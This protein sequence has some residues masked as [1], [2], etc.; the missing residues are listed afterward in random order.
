MNDDES[1]FDEDNFS[2]KETLSIY[3]NRWKWY[4]I[5]TFLTFLGGYF[6]AKYAIP[7]YKASS[8]MLFRSNNPNTGGRA[9]EIDM[10][11]DL[12]I[13]DQGS[14][15]DDEIEIL[16]SRRI[17]QKVVRKLQLQNNYRS[18]GVITGMTKRTIYDN[19]PIKFIPDTLFRD[20]EVIGTTYLIEIL[21]EDEFSLL[22]NNGSQRSKTV[23]EFGEKIT[24]SSN[25]FSIHKT[26]FFTDR[27]VNSKFEVDYLNIENAVNYYKNN[28]SFEKGE[29][30]SNVVSIIFQDKS[31]ERAEAFLNELMNQYNNDATQDNR[32]VAAN[33][34]DFINE[35]MQHISMELGDVEEGVE[36][37]KSERKLV[38]IAA[39][40]SI[41][42]E[43]ESKINIEILEISTQLKLSEFVLDY[44]LEDTLKLDLIP[45][46]LGLT[47]QSIG[48]MIDSHN[49]LVLERQKTLQ[50][51][52][53]KN[54]VVRNLEGQISELKKSLIKSLKKSVE[55]NNIQLQSLRERESQIMNKISK[56][57]EYERIYRGIMRQQQI[58][59]S[60]Y[61]YLLQKREEA[62]ISYAV[63]VNNA[64]I[65]DDAYGTQIPVTPKKK[66]VYILSLI[67]GIL[68]TT[69]GI[70]L[71]NLFDTKIHSH[72]DIEKAKLPVAG[73]LPF[74]RKNEQTVIINKNSNSV[75]AESLRLLR[76]NVYFLLG[77]KTNEKTGKIVFV[78]STIAKEGKSFISI[79]LATSF[80]L[81]NKK[82]IIVG[83][84]LRSPK[85]LSYLNLDESKGISNYII[86]Q[87][88]S[89]N[90]IIIKSNF[91]DNLDLLPSG[92]IP[93]NP[94]E[95]LLSERVA[96]MFKELKEKYDYIIVDT[97]PVGIV[98]DTLLVKDFADATLYVTRAE[99]LDKRMLEIP[100]G[101][102]K[103]KKLNNMAIVVNAT[104]MKRTQGFGYGYG[105]G[106]GYGNTQSKKWWQFWKK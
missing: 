60:L 19:L 14:N 26:A 103:D 11:E 78:T 47:D 105:Y 12:G 45:S 1:F 94:S 97:S 50:F 52:G 3:L 38:D 33:T 64:K 106:Y 56:V 10:F 2:I 92:D 35:R 91:N 83:L 24:L 98:T 68:L 58:K 104:D 84:D 51:S 63:S 77:S 101:L 66:S 62:A 7:E 25:I 61:I 87:E 48:R 39:E 16:K 55:V 5:V 40:S 65:I 49:K 9:N 32:L 70:Y 89:L 30:G 27:F 75:I 86:D 4:A 29:K 85:L 21:N 79:N 72:K 80:A 71:N 76:T 44:I 73:S 18:V 95:I 34:V 46:N 28:L 20:D 42:L 81:T 31:L 102:Y 90:E 69:V 37:F 17:I 36:K 67:I 43:N 99:Y 8:K 82:T 23:Y 22:E 93:P 41:Y 15:I 96:S 53:H 54:P 59:E 88:L 13:F 74:V 57:P 6:Y 100:K